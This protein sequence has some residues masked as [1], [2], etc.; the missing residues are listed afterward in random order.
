MY[1]CCVWDNARIKDV[2]FAFPGLIALAQHMGIPLSPLIPILHL[3]C[4]IH[5]SLN[6]EICFLVQFLIFFVFLTLKMY[7]W[8]ADGIVSSALC[9]QDLTS[10][11]S[12]IF[13]HG[14]VF[15][16]QLVSKLVMFAA[17]GASHR[18]RKF[19]FVLI[20]GVYR[21]NYLLISPNPWY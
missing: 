17:V 4:W 9:Q 1:Q 13:R 2:E 5:F 11:D 3:H 12:R 14:L 15:S 8:V 20:I 7:F 21:M 18:N 16:C 10:G 19:V 6:C